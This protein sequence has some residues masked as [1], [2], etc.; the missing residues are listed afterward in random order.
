MSIFERIANWWK[1]LNEEDPKPPL[2]KKRKGPSSKPVAT[3]VKKQTHKSKATN[4][5]ATELN[6][7]NMT[8][9]DFEAALNDLKWSIEAY[10]SELEMT[11]VMSER[12]TELLELIDIAEDER[13]NIQDNIDLLS[14][15]EVDP[16]MRDFYKTDYLP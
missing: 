9:A 11:D 5:P 7:D 12:Y 1:A 14:G 3:K 10:R 4:H 6:V 2:H 16:V 8:K 13:D 15:H